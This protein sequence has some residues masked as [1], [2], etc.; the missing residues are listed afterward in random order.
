MRQPLGVFTG[1]TGL[2]VVHHA[3]APGPDDK[4][5][6]RRQFVAA[7]GPATTAAVTFAALGGRAHLVTALG[8]GPV[9][10]LVREELE[11]LG[12]TIIDCTGDGDSSAPVAAILVNPQAGTRSVV[13]PD[14][15]QLSAVAPD[16]QPL[17]E[18]ADVALVDGHHTGL[19][20]AAARAAGTTG[21][22]LVV[23]AGRWKPVFDDV[24]PHATAMICAAGFPLPGPGLVA[25]GVPLAA[26]THGPEPVEWWTADDGGRIEVP[27]VEAADTLGAGDVFHGAYAYFSVTHEPVASLGLAVRVA[28]RKVASP[29]PRE[30]LSAI[31]RRAPGAPW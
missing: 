4:V 22:P 13:S 29:G 16:L 21:T 10:R 24:I 15:S 8:A 1:L 18:A 9:A 27:A 31:R 2:D 20:V 30:W 5:T 6:A 28:G 14:A 3:P 17:M 25:R 19:A 11:G 23:D 7:G 26:V 12:V